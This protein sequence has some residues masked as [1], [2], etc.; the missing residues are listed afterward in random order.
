MCFHVKEKVM[1]SA[2]L[3][4]AYWLNAESSAFSPIFTG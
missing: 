4:H 2:G 3:K 1:G